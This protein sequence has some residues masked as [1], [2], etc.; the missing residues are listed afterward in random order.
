M[1][2][3]FAPYGFRPVSVLGQE[4]NT[5]GFSEYPLTT[6]NGVAIAVGD[7]VALIAG[8]ITTSLANPAAGSISINTPVGIAWGFTYVDSMG[9]VWETPYLPASAVVGLGFKSITVKVVDDPNATMYLCPNAPSPLPATALGSN[10]GFTNYGVSGTKTQSTIAL[11]VASLAL[12]GTLPLRVLRIDRPEDAYPD[13]L[14]KWNWG[15]H[16]YQQGG[17]H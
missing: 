16:G 6:D 13:V 15:T 11:D 8:S 3:I 4:Y 1:S 9:K 17:S 5:N 7:P 10:A 2:Q 12:G 14:V